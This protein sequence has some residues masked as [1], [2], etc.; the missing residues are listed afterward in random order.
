MAL[1]P[2][3]IPLTFH[4][5]A[6]VDPPFTGVAVNVTELPVQT[7]FSDALILIDAG[8]IV[9]IHINIGFDVT[10]PVVHVRLEVNIQVIKSPLAGTQV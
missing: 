7:G 5:Y 4:W 10:G 3:T 1:D 8:T 9:F 6:G 2:L